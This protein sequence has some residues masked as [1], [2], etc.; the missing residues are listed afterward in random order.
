M[1]ST[2]RREAPWQRPSA[3]YR[4]SALDRASR[5]APCMLRLR[6]VR[7]RCAC[8][9]FRTTIMICAAILRLGLNMG[10]LCKLKSY[11]KRHRGRRYRCQR[12]KR[13]TIIDAH[14]NVR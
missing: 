6:G 5:F 11:G 13:N 12:Q 1:I 14:E 4:Q 2:L 7:A 9:L 10:D 8:R 3:R